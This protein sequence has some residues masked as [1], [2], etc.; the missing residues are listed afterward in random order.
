MAAPAPLQLRRLSLAQAAIGDDATAALAA[1]A[2]TL[3]S[4]DVSFNTRITDGSFLRYLGGLTELDLSLNAWV[5][6]DIVSVIACCM[7]RLSRLTLE[8]TDISDEGI[9]ALGSPSSRLIHSLVHLD[10]SRTNIHVRSHTSSHDA[11]QRLVSL[12]DL[13]LAYCPIDWD[14]TL[15]LPRSLERLKVSRAINFGDEAIQFLAQH[16]LLGALPRLSSLHLGSPHIT[17]AAIGALQVLAERKPVGLEGLQ[18]WHTKV[19]RDGRNALIAN[20]GLRLDTTMKSS[21]GTY[22][23]KRPDSPVGSR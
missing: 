11:L 7:P 17:D 1:M 4:L 22:L 3:T 5:N 12:Q 9:A 10:C 8:K 23:L 21:E 15:A 16:V 20:T 13:L 6:D 2:S 14:L 19:T 18:L